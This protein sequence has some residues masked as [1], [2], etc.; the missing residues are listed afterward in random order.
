MGEIA[1]ACGLAMTGVMVCGAHPTHR[2]GDRSLLVAARL[3]GAALRVRVCRR[4]QLYVFFRLEVRFHGP[5][6]GAGVF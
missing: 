2:I 4:L 5:G 6:G 1:S 3:I